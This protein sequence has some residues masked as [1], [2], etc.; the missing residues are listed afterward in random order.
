MR[1]SGCQGERT[2]FRRIC[3]PS[4]KC[5]QSSRSNFQGAQILQLEDGQQIADADI[6]LRHAPLPTRRLAI[7]VLWDRLAPQNYYPPDVIVEASEGVA[8]NARR[9]SDDSFR[10]NLFPDAK[11]TLRAQTV[12]RGKGAGTAKA[13][14]I[15][16]DGGDTSLSEVTLTLNRAEGECLGK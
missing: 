1:S 15:T 8:P 2:G 12:C 13:D 10:L 6:H 14:A 16:V 3:R 4:C 11:Y 7:R 9:L 5:S